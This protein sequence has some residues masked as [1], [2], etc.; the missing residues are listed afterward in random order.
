MALAT[1]IWRRGA[2]Y[3][4]RARVPADLIARVGRRELS[5]S[6]DTADPTTARLR[7]LRAGALLHAIWGTIRAN[8][9][10]QQEIDELL[11][12]W[13]RERLDKDRLDR[14]R[15][16]HKDEL[17]ERNEIL[18]EFKWT[19]TTVE[20]IDPLPQH[21]WEADEAEDE[22]EE[23]EHRLRAYRLD[24]AAPYVDDI[25][26]RNGVT[27][28]PNSAEYKLLCQ[29]VCRGMIE[30]WRIAK[31]RAQGDWV[32]EVRDPLFKPFPASVPL[33]PLERVEQRP[34]ARSLGPSIPLA[35]LLERCLKERRV[36]PKTQHD[37]RTALRALTD[38]MGREKP[39]EAIGKR[40]VLAL[41]DALLETPLNWSKRFPGKP[42][43]E[44]VKLNRARG[45]PTL[46]AKTINMKYLTNL[47]T[48]F[49]W[50][51][52]NG[53]M[54]MNPAEGVRVEISKRERTKKKRLPFTSEQLQKMF[55]A[56]LF[57]GCK[58]DT[59]IYEP[60]PTRIRDHRFWAPLLALFTGARANEL[61]QLEV[62]DIRVVEGVR[63]IDLRESADDERSEK[64]LKTAAAHRLVPLHPEL[65]R[66]GFF[67]YV[68]DL[69]AKREKRLFPAWEEGSDGYYS[70]TLSKF[71]ARFCDRFVTKD[72]RITFHSL[73]HC[74]VDALRRAGV[75]EDM[76]LALVG[77]E[78]G[79]SVHSS[80]GLGFDAPTLYEAVAKVSYPG[81]DLSHLYR[82]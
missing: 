50:V 67:A 79:D 74:F 35:D 52:A 57:V 45:L 78:P 62:A 25:L 53:H 32:D 5:R 30:F 39:I 46:S 42:L 47:R 73:R 54:E 36:V 3:Y 12:R 1:N 43:P 82:T 19:D 23:W 77:H 71:F 48:F 59:K 51:V 24:T 33:V 16:W 14:L 34:K 66:L 64:R 44:A 40:D 15:P 38:V 56:P 63:C 70:S 13:F 37:Y 20:P 80:Y 26:E 75:P 60:G 2:R 65:E 72:S 58:S 69:R 22:R 61:G 41:K 21:Q 10:T 68:E 8:N 55:T 18:A 27:L 49:S 28:D 6:L 76:R 4:Y 11:R 81:L 17:D 31:A 7:G 9:M 29:G